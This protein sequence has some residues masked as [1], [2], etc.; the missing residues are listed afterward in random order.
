MRRTATLLLAATWLLAG[1]GPALA[2]SGDPVTGYWSRIRTGLP[3]PVEPPDPVPEGGTWVSSDPTGPVAVSALRTR[4]AQGLVAVELRLTIAD[5][6]GTPAVQACPS[7]E[8][9][10]PEQGGRPEGAPAADCTAPIQ[11]AVDGDVLVVP[12]PAGLDVVNVLLRPVPGSS[13]SLTMERATAASVVTAPRRSTATAPPPSPPGP[14]P[15]PATSPAFGPALQSPELPP[16]V[17]APVDAAAPPLLAVP[18]LPELAAPAAPQAA[19]AP[20]TAPAPVTLAVPIARPAPALLPDDRPQ[21]LLA[22]GVLV[23][24]GA[25]AVRLARQPAVEPRALGGSARRSRPAPVMVVGEPAAS[26]GVGRFQTV[27][28]R[29]PVRI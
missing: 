23:L 2:A 5:A 12:L 28:D 24:L 16:L 29:P 11:A 25:Q 1:A 18:E 3:V 10:A 4:V 9:W 8:A 17:P 27:R 13:F 26:R 7:S 20:Q 22:A 6:I 14:P 21:A 19:P 15:G